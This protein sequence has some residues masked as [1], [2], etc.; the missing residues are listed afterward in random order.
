M[1]ILPRAFDEACLTSCNAQI[2]R[3]RNVLLSIWISLWGCAHASAA[4]NPK[5]NFIFILADDLGWTDLACYGSKFYQ[6]PNIDKLAAQGMKFTDAYAAC[7]VCSPT[8][9][10]LLTGQYPARLGLTDWIPG[11]ASQ[12][13]QKLLAPDFKKHLP[14]EEITWAEVLK[15]AGYVS[16]TIGKWHLGG[17]EFGSE[18]QGFGVSIAGSKSGSPASY[19][20][21]YRSQRG[22]MP[23]SP[24]SEGEYLTDRLTDE[25]LTFIGNNKS[26]PFVL[27][28]PHFAVHT[29]PQ[30]KEELIEK[31]QKLA[32]PDAPYNH[33][34]YAA[35]IESLDDSVGRIVEQLDELKLSE[36]TV[37][38]F[39]SDNGGLATGKFIATSNTPLRDGKGHLYEG[40]I[41]VPLIVKWNSQI[42]PGVCKTPVTSADVLPTILELGGVKPPKGIVF[43][44]ESFWPLLQGKGKLK[45][46][47][48]FWHYPHYSEEGGIPGAAIRQGDFKLIEWFENGRVELFNL[49]DDISETENLAEQMPLKAAE[50][51]TKLHVWRK[52]VDAQ[53]P[54]PNPNYVSVSK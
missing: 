49:R 29:P 48:I 12:P 13:D 16:A 54:S 33:A 21:P 4:E 47:E 39:S 22:A 45:R 51:K 50:L 26:A 5:P 53:M 24:G 28:L 17:K 11:Y 46:N 43:D 32:G 41:R 2:I 37:V 30:A 14:L 3:M 20:S 15:P 18:K 25:A 9:A 38:F 10:S 19:F 44:G 35:M 27:Y 1:W 6:T 8:R 52:S 7:P 36:R 42:K 23:L 31:Y 40:G 34:V